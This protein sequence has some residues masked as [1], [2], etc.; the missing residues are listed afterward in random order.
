MWQSTLTASAPLPWHLTRGAHRGLFRGSGC[1]LRGAPGL[2]MAH[3]DTWVACGLGAQAGLAVRRRRLRGCSSHVFVWGRHLMAGPSRLMLVCPGLGG[4]V[5]GCICRVVRLRKKKT[6]GRGGGRAS[7]F[8]VV[9]PVPL[10][11]RIYPEFFVAVRSLA[12]A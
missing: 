5:D 8:A 9:G 2:R 3:Q 1:R 10:A 7:A 11:K 6:L 12:A 4:R